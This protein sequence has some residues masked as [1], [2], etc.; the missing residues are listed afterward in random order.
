MAE[1]YL[2]ATVEHDGVVCVL[3]VRGELDVATAAQF[4]ESAAVALNSCAERF[5]LDLSELSFI[6]CSGARVLAATARAV[7]ATCPVIVRSVSPAV[8][9]LLNLLGLN[10]E[11]HEVLPVRHAALLRLESQLLWSSAQHASAESRRLA[12]IVAAT[13]E[14]V[15]DTL[16]RLADAK[17]HESARLATLSQAE[18]T[19]AAYAR[20]QV[21]R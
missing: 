16:S 14:R 10:L 6:D 19:R 17:P 4:A 8:R 7:P 2:S 9:R 18:R 11:R 13:A 1:D 3:A 21:T 5:V 12:V 15:A 20:S